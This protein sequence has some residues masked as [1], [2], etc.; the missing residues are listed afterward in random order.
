MEGYICCGRNALAVSVHYP[1]TLFLAH[2]FCQLMDSASIDRKQNISALSSPSLSPLRISSASLFCHTLWRHKT[3]GR[4]LQ[5]GSRFCIEINQCMSTD[6]RYYMCSL[7][8]GEARWDKNFVRCFTM[9]LI[10]NGTKKYQTSMLE[11]SNNAWI[12][13]YHWYSL[14]SFMFIYR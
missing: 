12:S 6:V 3:G 4:G 13:S 8:E 11:I 9:Y 7:G 10:R 1:F 2:T 14:S 5:G